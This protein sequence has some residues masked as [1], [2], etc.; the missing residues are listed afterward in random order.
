M[1]NLRDKVDLDKKG[2]ISTSDFADI[3]FSFFY[4]ESFSSANKLIEVK[5]RKHVLAQDGISFSS[6]IPGYLSKLK[7]L[8]EFVL[9]NHNNYIYPNLF[10]PFLCFYYHF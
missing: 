5:K 6:E 7:N 1:D 8:T 4:K 3:I 2:Y 9:N 10:Q